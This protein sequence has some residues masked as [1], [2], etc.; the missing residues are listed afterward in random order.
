MA[1]PSAT[2]DQLVGVSTARPSADDKGV[3]LLERVLMPSADDSGAAVSDSSFMPKLEVLVV[4]RDSRGKPSIEDSGAGFRLN[5]RSP[6]ID[7][8]VASELARLG[9]G[10]ELAA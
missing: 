9:G 6:N 3:G 4:R 5:R 7:E 2:S 1:G 8:K 10:V